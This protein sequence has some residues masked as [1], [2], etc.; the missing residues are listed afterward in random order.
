MYRYVY[1]ELGHSARNVYLQ[2]EA[3]GL[4]TVAV[5]AF[6]D[7]RVRELLGEWC[8]ENGLDYTT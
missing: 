8:E 4:G 6:V 3:L 1:I 5:G 7:D 2:A